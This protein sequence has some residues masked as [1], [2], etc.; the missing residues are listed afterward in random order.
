MVSVRPL[1]SLPVVA[2]PARYPYARR[3]GE[4]NDDP[5]LWTID[6]APEAALAT[7]LGIVSL[8]AVST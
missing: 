6:A 1:A 3:F 7:A 5:V 4:V 8:L 2:A